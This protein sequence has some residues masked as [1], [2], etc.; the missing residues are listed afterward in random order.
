MGWPWKKGAVSGCVAHGPCCSSAEVLGV[1]QGE[2]GRTSSSIKDIEPDH[3][4]RHS[5]HRECLHFQIVTGWG[6]DATP[7]IARFACYRQ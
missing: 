6:A 3:D 4:G 5:R 1:K 2:N 7:S